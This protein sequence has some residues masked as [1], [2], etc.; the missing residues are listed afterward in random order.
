M[1]SAT[2]IMVLIPSGLTVSLGSRCHR[3]SEQERPLVLGVLQSP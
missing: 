2:I 3:K 1:G